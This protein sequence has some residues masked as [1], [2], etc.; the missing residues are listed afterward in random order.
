MELPLLLLFLLGLALGWMLQS[1]R[2]QELQEELWSLRVFDSET[3][4]ALELQLQFH[5]EKEKEQAQAR[6]WDLQ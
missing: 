6:E 2:L 4:K 3:V 1:R 5:L